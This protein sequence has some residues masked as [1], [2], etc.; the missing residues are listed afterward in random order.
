MKSST[1][2]AVALGERLR[3]KVYEDIIPELSVAVAD[4]LMEKGYDMD[5]AGCDLAY[6]LTLRV[7]FRMLF[8]VYAED[9]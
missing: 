9:R 8:Q 5:P 1:Q 2:Y 3:D 6:Q 4:A 7:F